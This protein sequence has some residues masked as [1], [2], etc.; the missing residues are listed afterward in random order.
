[1]LVIKLRKTNH[2]D[3][4]VEGVEMKPVRLEEL[5]LDVDSI[6]YVIFT[7]LHIITDEFQDPSSTITNSLHLLELHD[8]LPAL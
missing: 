7:V 3:N 5:E 1:M 2:R 4:V 6:K 8:L